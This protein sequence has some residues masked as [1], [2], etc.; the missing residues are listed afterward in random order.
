MPLQGRLYRHQVWEYTKKFMCWRTLKAKYCHSAEA[1][2][3]DAAN[4]KHRGRP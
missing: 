4:E 3:E 1:F 2:G